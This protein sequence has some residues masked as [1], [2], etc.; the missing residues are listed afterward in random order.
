[1]LGCRVGDAVVGAAGDDVVGVEDSGDVAAFVGE[2]TAE[3]PEHALST[4]ANTTAPA[5]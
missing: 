1:V 5:R 4:K 3:M 2:V